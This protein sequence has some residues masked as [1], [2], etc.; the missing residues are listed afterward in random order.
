M[1]AVVDVV[2]ILVSEWIVGI[3]W[4][5]YILPKLGIGR[6]AVMVGVAE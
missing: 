4:E 3:S 5:G 1:A 2:Q 6:V